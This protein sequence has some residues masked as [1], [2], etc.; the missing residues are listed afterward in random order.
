[1]SSS[2]T[3][4][5]E[6]IGKQDIPAARRYYFTHFAVALTLYLLWCSNL[7][8]F[9]EQL[10]SCYTKIAEVKQKCHSVILIILVYLLVDSFKGV[11]KGISKAMGL[12]KDVLF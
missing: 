7:Y 12:Y 8:L 4:I 5:G 6:Q 2:T 11:Y 9:E 3:L 10:I 1:M